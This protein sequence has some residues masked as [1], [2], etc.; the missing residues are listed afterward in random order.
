MSKEL[1]FSVFFLYV[2]LYNTSSDNFTFPQNSVKWQVLTP[3]FWTWM[4]WRNPLQFTK[5]YKRKKPFTFQHL[6]ALLEI[7]YIT[8][9]WSCS[10]FTQPSIN[11]HQFQKKLKKLFTGSVMSWRAIYFSFSCSS[12]TITKQNLE[13]HRNH[14]KGVVIAP[15][16]F[17]VALNSSF[18]SDQPAGLRK[19]KKKTKPISLDKH[20]LCPCRQSWISQCFYN[21]IYLP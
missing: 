17:Y 3:L 21:L 7:M 8:V 12:Q 1:A 6:L 4:H 5:V 11:A 20:T 13:E 14:W 15:S 9:C 18:A 16:K 10:Y 19:A 2:M